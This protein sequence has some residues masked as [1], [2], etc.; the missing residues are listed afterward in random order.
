MSSSN[1]AKLNE[2]TER[3]EKRLKEREDEYTIYKQFYV[4][5]GTFNVNNRQPPTNILLEEWLQCAKDNDCRRQIHPDIIAVGF[6]EIDTSSGAY[7]YDDRRKEDEWECVVRKTIE[8]CYK[9]KIDNQKFQ[10]L[11]RIRL[12]GKLI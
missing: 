9:S 12:M 7:I 1:Y 2:A 8:S 3:F 5:I 4:L 11:N 10:L 6:Q